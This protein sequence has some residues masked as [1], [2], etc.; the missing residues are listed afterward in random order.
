MKLLYR[1]VLTSDILDLDYLDIVCD[2]HNIDE[3]E[4]I[5]RESLDIIVS[6]NVLHHLKDP[7]KYLLNAANLLKKGGFVIITEPYFSFSSKIIYKKIHHEYSSFD[8]KE[9]VISKIEGPLKSANIA[10]S[11]LIFFGNR[12]WDN[13]LKAV[14]KVDDSSINYFSAFSYFLTGGISRKIR[15]PF[16]LYKNYFKL[17]LKMSQF[18]PDV[19]SS[20]FTLRLENR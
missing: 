7:L 6:I 14:Y 5:K 18:L 19:F 8:I 10:L 15:V 4:K 1:N 16:R 11:F 20:F 9:P 12:G 3:Y 17:D 13:T 2:C